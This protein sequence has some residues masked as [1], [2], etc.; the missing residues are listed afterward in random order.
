[1]NKETYIQN[2]FKTV[3]TN[4]TK[5]PTGRKKT[6]FPTIWIFIKLAKVKV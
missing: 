3:E 1:M 5:P 6:I 2:Y 4:I